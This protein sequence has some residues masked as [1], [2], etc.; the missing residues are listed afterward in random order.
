MSAVSG[1]TPAAES[2]LHGSNEL[3]IVWV[4]LPFWPNEQHGSEGGFGITTVVIPLGE[5]ELG[6]G[7]TSSMSTSALSA[8]ERPVRL[9]VRSVNR[10]GAAAAAGLRPG[11]TLLAFEC[12]SSVAALHGGPQ[13]HDDPPSTLIGMRWGVSTDLGL[14]LVARPVVGKAL[15]TF[16]TTAW[17]EFGTGGPPPPGWVS[18]PLSI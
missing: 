3:T 17:D 7:S 4:E 1:S 2:E 16:C 14:G 9:A 5:T 8:V 12:G 11:D 10:N 18:L 6:P 15:A 13:F